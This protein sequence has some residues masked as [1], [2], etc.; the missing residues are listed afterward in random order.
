MN[1]E[2]SNA[3]KFLFNET[4]AMWKNDLEKIFKIGTRNKTGGCNLSTCI[5]VFIGIESFSLFFS[6]GNQKKAFVAFINKFYLDFYKNNMDQ[7][8]SLFRHGLAHNFYPKSKIQT[9]GHVSQ[10]I[11]RVNQDGKVASLSK[12]KKELDYFRHSQN[13][14]P[15]QT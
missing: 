2:F 1:K 10:I 14:T 4:Y 15:P 3:Y 12:I 6:K 9:G 13:L 5:L 11:F 7:V 8:Y